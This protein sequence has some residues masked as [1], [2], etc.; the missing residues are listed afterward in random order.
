MRQRRIATF[1]RTI[2]LA[3]C[4]A[5]AAWATAP[6]LAHEGH[7]HAHDT[8][9]F[10]QATAWPDRVI[11]TFG[12][13][14]TTSFSVTWRTAAS[15]DKA[16]AQFVK[17]SADA[18]FDLSAKTFD[19]VTEH[20]DLAALSTAEGKAERTHNAG[21]PPVNYH[22]ITFQDLEPATRYAWRVGGG[23]GKWSEWY[24]TRTAPREGPISFVYMGD[25]QQG[26]RS[27]WS[28]VI[29]AAHE[30]A[31]QADFMLH[32]GDLVQNGDH[33]LDWAEWF[34]AGSFLHARIP[35]VPVV[36]NHEYIPV[37]DPASGKK[38]R[39][40]TPLWR[41][42]FTLPVVNELPESLHEAVYDVKYT[43]DLHLFVLNS[44]PSDYDAQ[45]AWLDRKL[46]ETK[47]RWR[48][49]TM[50]HPYFIP[51]H[52]NKDG[53]NAA[54]IAAF[55]PVINKHEVDLVI[56]GHI[57]TYLRSTVPNDPAEQPARLVAGDPRDVK[58]VFVISSA[59]AGVG[60]IQTPDWIA[61]NVGDGKPEKGFDDL[62][63]DRTAGNSPMFQVIRINGDK[64]EYTAH[65]AIGDV[66]D[67]FTVT[68]NGRQ[69]T[70]IDG[71]EAFG[72]TRLFENTG[73]YHDWQDLDE[74][75]R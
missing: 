59:G 69:K 25:A 52:S 68:K 63:A 32:A 44:A 2:A 13:D 29:R 58:T 51:K 55:T 38:Y 3:C 5:T 36:G 31:P 34:A 46:S 61:K 37:I 41:A 71:A 17:A 54:R 53:D 11:T 67:R 8:P 28:R 14:P 72:D 10:Q 30:S 12:V 18:R 6:L 40:L 39:V 33:D 64:L 50:H 74:A 35:T 75:R 65:T 1:A 23:E 70:L 57:H 15:V 56:V 48:I 22:S 24:Q 26:I 20:A 42:Q 60:Q 73:P 43:P 47:S 27:H 16:Q 45:A 4:T 66:Y 21:L 19:A 62:S 49:V 9:P 7:D